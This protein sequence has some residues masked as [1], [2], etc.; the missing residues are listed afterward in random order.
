MNKFIDDF[1]HARLEFLAEVQ[2][3]PT[4]KRTDK[5]FER[6]SL[7]DVLVHITAW[8]MWTV[9][10][11]GDFRNGLTPYWPPSIDEFNSVAVSDSKGKSWED[12]YLELVEAGATLIETYKEIPDDL[13]D[14]KVWSNR[15]S[16]IKK[17]LS[18]EIDHYKKEHLPGI[19][20]LRK[21]SN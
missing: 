19:L 7:Q 1:K 15:N 21:K 12:I 4:D 16:T 20:N 8:D 18:I 9:E 6:W 5:L 14:K 17:L 10:V 13:W 11:V 2:L 3:F